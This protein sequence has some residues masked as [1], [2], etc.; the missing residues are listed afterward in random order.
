MTALTGELEEHKTSQSGY[1]VVRLTTPSCE[2]QNTKLG[3]PPDRDVRLVCIKYAACNRNCQHNINVYV[4]LSSR[5]ADSQ[6]L[7]KKLPV[8]MV[9]I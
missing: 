3:V 8:F 4:M 1:P 6:L 9:V 2:T 7:T 5:A